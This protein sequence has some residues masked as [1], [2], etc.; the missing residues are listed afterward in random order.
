MLAQLYQDDEPR[1]FDGT[2]DTCRAPK[3]NPTAP[4]DDQ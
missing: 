3:R 4:P 1:L 2:V